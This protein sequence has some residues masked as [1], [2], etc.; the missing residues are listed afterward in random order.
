MLFAHVAQLAEAPDLGS[1]CCKFDSYRGY[2]LLT[3]QPVAEMRPL[4]SLRG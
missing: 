4:F 1:G 2:Q 3:A